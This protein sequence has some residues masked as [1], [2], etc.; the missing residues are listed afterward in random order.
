MIPAWA[1]GLAALH[2]VLY[3]AASA[4]GRI[5][6][7]ELFNL[8]LLVFNLV[9]A[10][11]MARRRS[12]PLAT[13]AMMIMVIAHTFIGQQLAPDHLTSGA[14]LLAN[15]LTVYV[16]L[17]LHRHM[18]RGHWFVFVVSFFSL[19]ALLAV[20][21]SNGQP[22]FILFLLA[23]NACARSLRLMAY[24]WALTLSFTLCQPYA[25]ESLF[26]FFFMITASFGAKGHPVSRTALAFL[27]CGMSLLFLVLLP[28][29]IVI[30]GQD[31]HNIGSV[32]GDPRIRAAIRTTALTATVS[33]LLLAAFIIPL[34]YAVARLRFPGRSLL[35]A[36]LDLPIVIPQSAAGIALIQV[37]GSRQPI[38][39]ALAL[40]GGIHIDGTMIGICIAQMFVSVPFMARSSIQ[41]FAGV[42]EELEL[43]AR[44]LGAPT[45]RVFLRIALPLASRGVFMGTI[46]AWARAAGEFGAVL[47]VAPTP[48]TAPVSVYNRFNSVGLAE[49]GPLVASLLLF[50][51]VMFFMLQWLSYHL[52]GAHDRRNAV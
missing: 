33:T 4:I 30:T 46:L 23:M 11:T 48:E 44:A 12:D 1:W 13:G 43:T 40:Y 21:T 9:A 25:W 28:V 17:K 45:R 38:G 18:P 41:A 2:V 22:L 10:A 50:S 37:F 3:G 34:S 14:M 27:V 16:G 51:L 31:L 26:I 49:S 47:F 42:D 29:L 32:L 7:F 15:M 8:I 52:P 19:Y 6:P 5:A 24:F 39:E 20:Y 35:L 36:F